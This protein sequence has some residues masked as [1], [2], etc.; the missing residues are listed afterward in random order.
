M[1]GWSSRTFSIAR[2][3]AIPPETALTNF[4]AAANY[5]AQRQYER[6]LWTRPDHGGNGLRHD[7]ESVASPGIARRA[8]L[9]LGCKTIR[10]GF[11]P[12]EA[13]HMLHTLFMMFLLLFVQEGHPLTGTWHGDWG[14][15]RDSSE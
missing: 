11:G 5:P 15:T 3:G 8:V 2:T 4:K 7:G 9:V 10:A 14:P 12:R 13:R 6:R 1:S